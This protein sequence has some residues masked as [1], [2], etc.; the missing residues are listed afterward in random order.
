M[1]RVI[2]TFVL[3][4]IIPSLIFGQLKRQSEPVDIKNSIVRQGS[5]DFFGLSFID[6]SKMQMSHSFSLSY[7]SAGDLGVTQSLYLNT[8]SY[9]IANPLFLK[10]QWG[11]QNFPYNSMGSDNPAFKSGF[12]FSG[13]E[14]KYKPSKNF[15]IKFEYSQLPYSGYY[16]NRYYRDYFWD[17]D[18]E[19]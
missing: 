4:G 19:E 16:N 15:M 10:V 17:E 1:R 6:P 3:I 7:L 2:F 5:N 13:A 12:V 14:L 8:I 11:I 18:F 9:Q